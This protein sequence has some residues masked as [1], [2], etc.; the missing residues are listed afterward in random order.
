VLGNGDGEIAA[1]VA[2]LEAGPSPQ[3][4]GTELVVPVES[5]R[6]QSSG[7]VEIDLSDVELAALRRWED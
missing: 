5:L 1:V 7:L 4:G 6:F 3:T 2:E